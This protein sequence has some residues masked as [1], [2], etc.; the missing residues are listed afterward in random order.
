MMGWTCSL[1]RK[2]RIHWTFSCK[3]VGK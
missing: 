3:S 2:T 1:V